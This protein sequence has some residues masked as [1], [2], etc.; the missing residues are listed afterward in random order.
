MPPWPPAAGCGDFRNARTLSADEIGVFEAW[1]QAG[2]P[3]GDPATAPSSAVA[4]GVDLGP[5]S[6]TLD[7]GVSYSPNA[8]ATDDY[9]CFLIDPGLAAAQDLIGLNVHPGTPQIVHHVLV[10]A[11]PPSQVADA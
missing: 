4:P 7:P 9:H 2:A 10:F 5:P 6:A 8:A 3:A 11:L 1:D